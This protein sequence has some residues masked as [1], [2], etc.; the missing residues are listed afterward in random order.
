[1]S[2]LNVKTSKRSRTTSPVISVPAENGATTYE[3]HPAYARDTKS[4]L[5]LLG[6]TNFVGEDTFY[7]QSTDRDKRFAALA[8]TVAV[9]DIDWMTNFVRW[10]RT[11]AKMRSAA[12]VA[13]AEGVRARLS[14]PLAGKNRQL[15][16]AALQ[17]ADEPGEFLGYW[18]G[19]WGNDLPMP[20]KRGVADAAIRMYTERN[21]VKWDSD[22]RGWR[23]GDVIAMTRPRPKATWQDALFEYILADRHNRAEGIPEALSML[24]ARQRLLA[25]PV[26]QRREL[27]LDSSS[28]HL[29]FNDAGMTWEALSGWIQGP[30]DKVAWEAIIPEMQVFA[31]LRNLRNFDEQGISDQAAEKV[32]AKITSAEEVA[33]SRIL[34]MRVLSAY[35][36]APSDRWKH[37]LATTMDLT[38]ANIPELPGRT[39]IMVDTSGSMHMPFSKDGTL[40]RWD[41][42]TLF[43]LALAKRNESRADIVSFS[44]ETME[45]K[46]RKGASVLGE[47]ARWKNGGYFM[48][49]GTNTAEAVRRHF[50]G[51]DRVM[52]LTDEQAHY[53]WG[54]PVT[55]AVPA[56]VPM[57][58]WNLAGYQHG[59]TPSGTGN[60]HTF[61][62]L[63]DQAFATVP[64]IE[65]AQNAS[66]PWEETTAAD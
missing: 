2:K 63:N 15:I 20:V 50:K 4:E 28:V 22:R 58:T 53:G 8:R 33:G 55:S 18:T 26:E 54:G 62:G 32:I 30:M 3:G 24:Q 43:G 39:L 66:W 45:F 37:A 40:M 59:H 19:K 65:A 1:M 61:G 7:E 57:Y 12:V 64:M 42:A 35:N 46:L 47:L 21:F 6:V 17:R 56:A 16:V 49:G 14:T 52:V 34:P 11:G 29:L 48:G 27:L 51:H 36:A 9:E 31:L 10:L 44:S 38:T 5:F 60:R 25:T 13:A 23:F 41:S